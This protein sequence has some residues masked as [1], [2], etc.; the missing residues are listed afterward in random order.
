VLERPLPKPP[1]PTAS[2]QRAR[3]STASASRNRAYRQRRKA[4]QLVV[5]IVIDGWVLDLLTEAQFL[6]P[7]DCGDRAA[8]TRAVQAFLS[9]QSRYDV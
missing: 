7:W 8:I 9:F 3:S 4:G 5:T 6:K 1:P 2:P